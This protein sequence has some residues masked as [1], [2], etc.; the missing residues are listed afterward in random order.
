MG[1]HSSNSSDSN[2]VN[3][4]Y[5]VI[6]SNAN[7]CANVNT[8]S[9][10]GF[11]IVMNLSSYKNQRQRTNFSVLINPRMCFYFCCFFSS[12]RPYLPYC[13]STKPYEIMQYNDYHY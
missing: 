8:S 12:R 5:I 3:S 2:G 6:D 10:C 7:A 1:K 11:V 4:V 13:T 9:P